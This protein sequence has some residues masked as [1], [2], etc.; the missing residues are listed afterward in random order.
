MI[1][2]RMQ[3]TL[4]G[5]KAMAELFTAGE[6]LAKQFGPENVYNFA[7]GN[8]N[9]PAPASVKDTII[10][11]VSNTPEVALHSYTGPEGFKDVRKA[12]AEHDREKYG[13]DLT[14]KNIFMVAG[15]GG[16]LNAILLTLLDEGDEV[17]VPAPYFPEYEAYVNNY[18]GVLIDVPTKPGTFELDPQEI[19]KAITR[20]T[21][22]VLINTPNNPT[23]VV[24][25]E[26]NLR[27]LEK[28]LVDKNNDLGIDITL[29]SDEP[30]RDLIYGD[31]YVPFIPKFYDNTIICYSFSKSLSLPG[32]RIGYVTLPD[33]VTGFKEMAAGLS[34]AIRSTFVN[35]P[36]I[37]QKVAA[38]CINDE[39]DIAYYERNRDALFKGL[40][41]I[42]YECTTPNG[43][44]YLWLKAPMDDDAEFAK[45]AEDYGILVVPGSAFKGP[46][47]VRVSYCVA[48]ETIEA[49]LPKF[50]ELFDDVKAGK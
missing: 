45:K 26:E 13:V 47:Y 40:T 19:K 31:A 42:G 14:E 23:G 25:T 21:K 18:G 16:G 35:A 28:V 34:T 2:E 24:Y 3:R 41:D 27:D 37:M 44:F 46:G 36:A 49:A 9:V 10:D 33:S 30:Y 7:I 12:I 15:A 29:V 8:P 32:E 6:R 11:L 17:I 39:C 43:A 20:K 22:V 1:S 38:A 5:G 48:Y 4:E 50:K